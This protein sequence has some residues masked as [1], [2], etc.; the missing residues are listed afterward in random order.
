MFVLIW[1]T[2]VFNADTGA[3]VGGRQQCSGFPFEFCITLPEGEITAEAGLCVVIPCSFTTSSNFIPRNLVWY[4]CV[5]TEQRCSYSDV[6]FNTN[7]NN[8][9]IQSEFRGR[10]SQLEPDVSQR[11]C[12]IIINDLKESD[13][14]SYQLRVNGIL[15]GNQDGLR[16]SPRATVSIKALT[17][18]PE[19]TIP[20]LTEGQQTTLTCTAPGL[21]SG[22]DPQITWTWRGAGEKGSHITGN[23]TDFKTE[24]LTAVTQRHSSTLTFNA[25]AEHHGTSVTCKVSF[26]GN[27]ATEETVTLNVTW[28]S[29]ILKN[30]RCEVQSELLTCVCITEGIPLP[31]IKWPLL[32]NY[33]EYSVITT[34]TN[35]TVN[36]TVILTVKDPSNTVVDC[37]SGN[38]NGEAKMNLNIITS[39]KQEG[40][41][42]KR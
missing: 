29:K 21:C 13:S 27:A 36:S 15:N 18:K 37:V 31:T 2:L 14:G 7:K 20:P 5:S 42:E 23:I 26:T 8:I 9:K 34:V 32:K 22:S 1:V 6:I 33:T 35:H 3:S 12:S 41:Q 4:K 10:V 16:Y 25:S 28:F 30:S 19:V 11:N 17:Q 24:S 40:S 38:E 39:E